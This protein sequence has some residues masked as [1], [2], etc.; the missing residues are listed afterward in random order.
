MPAEVFAKAPRR[1]FIDELVLAKLQN[2]NIPPSP[3]AGRRRVHPPGV[4]RHD[5]RAAHGRRDPGVSG[6]HVARQ[7]RQADRRAAGAAGV[8]RLLGVQVVRP[9]AGQQRAAGPAG[10]VGVLLLDSQPRRGQHAVGPACP[11]ARDRH[12]QHAGKRRG[13]LLRPAPGSA[14]T[15][16]RPTSVAFL[17]MSINCATC[18][19]HPLEKWTNDQYYAMANLFARVRTKVAPGEGNAVIY[20]D[21]TGE[22]V[23]PLTGKPQPPTPLDGEAAGAGAPERS[24]R[25]PGRLAHVARESRTSAARSPTACGPTS[26]ASAWSRRSTTCGSP[27]R[28]ATRSC[29]P[30]RRAIWSDNKFDLKVADAGHPAIGHV[31]AQQPAAAGERGRRAVLLALLSAA[32]DGRGAARRHVAGQRRADRVSRLSA[33]HGGRCSCPTRKSRRIS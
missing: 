10:D 31:S 5:R 20:R 28:P 4:S 21:T 6:R 2:L 16:P 8:R 7:A 9:A 3:P 27:I 17:G 32:A 18:H 14:R 25:A 29:W 12:G 1:N 11:R 15:W 22:L 19:N 30:R 26:S 24:P 13:Q 23:Q 33:R